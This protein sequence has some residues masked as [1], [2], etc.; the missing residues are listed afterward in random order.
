MIKDFGNQKSV[1]YLLLF[2]CD[3]CLECKQCRALSFANDYR[4]IEHNEFNRDK[5][6][7]VLSI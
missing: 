4:K 1:N 6:V 5:S 7:P 3:F 2:T